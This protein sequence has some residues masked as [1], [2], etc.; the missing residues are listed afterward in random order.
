MIR[1]TTFQI[2]GLFAFL[3]LVNSANGQT[4]L[5]G[6]NTPDS[7]D[8][9]E[10]GEAG[11]DDYGALPYG[12]GHL[13]FLS[14]RGGNGFTARDPK[15]NQPFARPY[16]M[17]LK[18][19][20]TTPYNLPGV[21]AQQKY[22][23]GLCA[24]LPDSSGLIASHSRSKPYSNGVVG[25][26]L[27]FIPF[28]GDKAKELPFI[29]VDADY[30]HPYFDPIDY[31]LY[32]TSNVEGGKGGYDIYSS[33][34]SFDGVWSTPSPVIAANTKDDEVFPSVGPKLTLFFSRS[35]RN[36]GLQG[37][38]HRAGDSIA[39]ELP[40]N[41]RGD[42]FGLIVL[43]DSTAIYSQSKRPGTAANLHLYKIPAPIPEDTS[44]VAEETVEEAADSAAIAIA[45]AD[46]VAAYNASQMAAEGST[47]KDSKD[48]KNWTTD[49][50]PEPRTT[51]G[52]SLIVGGFVERDLADNFLESISGWAP[53][54]FLSR[55]NKK[56]YVVHSVH[57]SRADADKA[58]ASVNNR[59]YRAW[60]L[61]K[62]LK[63]I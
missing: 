34:L 27:S 19:F 22:Y 9:F 39:V 21:L 8:H 37:M 6:L 31:T 47:S 49:N 56:Y 46:S 51:S 52:Y 1:N 25:M 12:E 29:D 15:T 18:D 3:T 60:V 10:L 36:Y 45:K 53:E 32:F 58:K 11:A 57:N 42:D 41:G 63:E 43:D 23:I 30:Q 59:D 2:L 44:A 35:S 5:S 26:T 38:M 40:I 55:Y 62:G 4:I 13:L 20:K 28:N 14:N 54:A 17:R 50:S 24:L 16:L 7:L 61:S 48:T 33:T